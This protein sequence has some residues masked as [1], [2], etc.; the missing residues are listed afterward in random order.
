LDYSGQRLEGLEEV[1]I[2][3]QGLEQTLMLEEEEEEEKIRRRGRGGEEVYHISCCSTV[4]SSQGFWAF[5][6]ID[7]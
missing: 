4:E 2:G 3:S 6:S 1:S 5:I 7:I